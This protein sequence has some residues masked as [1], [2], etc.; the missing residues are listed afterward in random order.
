[1]TPRLP[2]PRGAVGLLALAL[3]VSILALPVSTSG[4]ADA[5]R[6]TLVN[7][8]LAVEGE[9]LMKYRDLGALSTHAWIEAG[10]EAEQ[11]ETLD[12]HGARRL[13]SRRFTTIELLERLRAEPDVEYAEPNYILYSTA[14]PN[15]PLFANL[16]GLL[17]TGVNPVGGGGTS[18]ADIDV[19]SAWDT[20]TGSRTHVVG[21]VDTGIDYTHPDLAANVWSAPGTFQVTVGGQTITCQAGT[22]GF[23]AITR[24]CD[25]RDDQFHGTHVAGTIGAVGNNGVGVVGVNWVASM[26]GLKFLGS[27][28]S[29]S[30]S[31]AIA[32][33]E[34]AIQAKA[35]F[36]S[37][38][39][40]NVR[41]LSNS[42]GG[43]GYSSALVDAINAANAADILFVA[44]AGNAASNNDASP[45]YPAS[46]A[47][48]NMV[49]VASSTSAD[50]LSSFSNYGAT[51]VHLAAPGSAIH[52]TMPNN[53]YGTLQGTSMATPH[54]SGAAMLALS[55]CSATT[56][57]LKSLL[58]DNVDLVPAFATKTSTGG[59]LNASRTVQA[60]QYPRVSSLALVPDLASPRAPGTTITWT[61][62]AG[63]GEAPYQYQWVVFDGTTWSD[64]TNWQ[65]SNTFAWTPVVASTAYQVAV[66]ARS[67]WNSGTREM[68][69]SQAFTVMP[70]VTEVDLTSSVAAPQGIGTTVTWTASA[71]GGQAPY[72]YQWAV[73]DGAAWTTMT[74][75]STSSTFAW[76]PASANSNYQV[77]VRARSAWNTGARELASSQAFAIMPPVTSLTLAA[78]RAAPQAPN[79]TITLTAAAGGGQAPYQYQWVLFN[80]TTWS[81]LTAWQ[82]GNTYAWTPGVANASYQVAVRARSAWNSGTREMSRALPYAIMPLVTGL[83]LAPSVASPQGVGTAVTW[84]AAASGGQAPYQYQFA[85]FNGTSWSDLYRLAVWQR[86]HV[87]ADG[88]ERRLPGRRAGARFVERRCARDGDIAGL[89]RHAK[90]DCRHAGAERRI[91][92]STRHDHHVDRS[93]QRWAGSVPIPV[94]PVQRLDLGGP[95]ELVHDRHLRLDARPCQRRLPGRRA[96][97]QRLEQRHARDG[98][99]A[100]V[101]H[102]AAG[103]RPDALTEPVI[104]AGARHDH[105]VD[106]SGQ[107]W[108]G[109]LSIPVCPVEWRQLD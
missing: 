82:S 2:S 102:H 81:D 16:W 71:S 85:L 65:S 66:R 60:C 6:H 8:H 22:H 7:G 57:Q 42:W 80:G 10:V 89:R 79:T 92:T 27:S 50:Q 53:A 91:A 51:S 4:R 59:R 33:I 105:H 87:D 34:F 98:G 101:R 37:T 107:R 15:D 14:V 52:S 69:R 96:R 17:N 106:R 46:Y 24:T 18:G 77:A 3:A 45:S 23:N 5:G 78:D 75:W 86:L 55:M 95:H 93:R 40:A 11:A 61:A 56:A 72:Q 26:M 49:A 19:S 41:V 99:H 20:S 97:P 88:R 28:G 44:A 76:T 74:S 108:P 47:T 67:A 12:R 103:N 100:A 38:G 9:V 109:A 73:Y 36:S 54:V 94:C 39:G 64:A 21:V 83:T 32:A 13:R 25:P 48:A 30:T 90:G 43:G 58:L 35:A 70:V 63:G 68:S 29:G 84:T 31:D 104:A 1:M 62:T